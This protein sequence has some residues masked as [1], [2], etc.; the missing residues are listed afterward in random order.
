G[1]LSGRVREQLGDRAVAEGDDQLVVAHG[2]ERPDEQAEAGLEDHV[3]GNRVE[4]DGN[5]TA[6]RGRGKAEASITGEGRG[7][8]A[9]H[10]RND[11]R[12]RVA[13]VEEALAAPGQDGDAAVAV[14]GDQV[15]N[16]VPGL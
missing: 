11:E 10:V 15:G 16:P 8:E 14:G 12:E 1:E 9:G 7:A 4:V 3:G 13:V 6:V 5:D 2:F